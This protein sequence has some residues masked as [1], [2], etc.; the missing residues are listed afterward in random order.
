MSPRHD[1]GLTLRVRF[2]VAGSVLAL[3]ALA[4]P[5]MDAAS[6]ALEDLIGYDD[7]VLWVATRVV[8]A[9]GTLALVLKL[10]KTP[11]PRETQRAVLFG[12]GV[13][14]TLRP[15]YL[16]ITNPGP[17][18]F[19]QVGLKM[20]RVFTP[21][22]GLWVSFLAAAL[23]LV[24]AVLTHRSDEEREAAEREAARAALLRDPELAAFAGP[25]PAPLS[26]PEDSEQ[27]AQAPGEAPRPA[28]GFVPDPAAVVPP[29]PG[30]FTPA[31]QDR[32]APPRTGPH[33]AMP[34]AMGDHGAYGSEGPSRLG[35]TANLVTLD[36]PYA[37]K[38]AA[39]AAHLSLLPAASLDDA[40]AG[41]THAP[42]PAPAP[43]VAPAPPAPPVAPPAPVEAPT[44]HQSVAPPGFG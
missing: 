6:P 28:P 19:A 34:V 38:T 7:S 43:P 20:G 18:D 16:I 39:P 17:V 1:R 30:P 37:P 44:R 4:L 14:Y 25:P 40:P 24:A 5:W 2:A 36:D 22:Y 11:D 32:P 15:A 29:M 42:Q 26:R 21:S 8:A 33:V 9:V 41:P 31:A 23:T 13:V 27:P 12:A 10:V 3:V 35:D